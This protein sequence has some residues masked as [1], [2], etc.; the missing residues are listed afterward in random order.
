MATPANL[1]PDGLNIDEPK[2]LDKPEYPRSSSQPMLV[3]VAIPSLVI[4]VLSLT[5]AVIA[6][7]G[8]WGLTG[9]LLY[10]RQRGWDGLGILIIWGFYAFWSIIGSGVLSLVSI[11]AAIVARLQIRWAGYLIPFAAALFLW[12]VSI[13]VCVEIVCRC[14]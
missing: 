2:Y 14:H 8:L 13:I 10:N 1:R 6:H 11:L 9:I 12:I 3:F 4:A 5:V 7:A